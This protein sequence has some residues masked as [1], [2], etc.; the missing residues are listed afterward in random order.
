[1]SGKATTDKTATV[2]KRLV[3]ARQKMDE[4]DNRMLEL[5]QQRQA[6]VDQ[7][8]EIKAEEGLEAYQPKRYI[9]MMKRISKKAKDMGLDAEM[10]RIIWNTMHQSSTERQAYLLNAASRGKSWL[11]KTLRT[12]V[13]RR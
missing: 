5:L 11:Y 7:I 1:M 12:K 3:Q 10:V 4:V 6:I 13:T 9:A 2:S 8:A